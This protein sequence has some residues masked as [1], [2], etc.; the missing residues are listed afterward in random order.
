MPKT[1]VENGVRYNVITLKRVAVFPT[2][3]GELR[4]DAL[5]IESEATSGSSI[6]DPFFSMRSRYQPV[7]LSSRPVRIVGKA[8]PENAPP[9][10][11][12][13]VGSFRL[14]ASLDRSTMEVGES[15]QL[16][17][18][19]SGSGNIATLEGPN[20]DTPGIFEV[21]DPQVATDVSRTGSSVRGTK[22][23]TYI[24]VPR[25]NGTFE[26]P[27]IEFSFLNPRSGRYETLRSKT[28][29]VTVTGEAA[30]TNITAATS[31]GL[32]VDD[33]APITLTVSDWVRTDSDSI[34]QSF[35]VYL[36][37]ILPLGLVAGVFVY[38]R[39]NDKLTNDVT[40]ARN[41]R[42]HPIARKHLKRA[43]ELLEQGDAKGYY[44]ELDRA[45]LGFVGDRLDIGER[46]LTRSELN[47]TLAKA[48][49][50]A[51]A[52]AEVNA[53]LDECDQVRFAP[54]PPNASAMQTAMDRSSVLIQRIHERLLEVEKEAAA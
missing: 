49:I 24:L 13:A 14:S 40:Y 8:F 25:S 54:V 15:V 10:F 35:L 30:T 26:I 33:I 22:T 41:R 1:V 36:F 7:E 31:A 29:S 9:S 20:V 21:Y 50:Q 32:P 34:H 5:K 43:A 3:T 39:I 46:A 42:A 6:R 17:I 4:V 48:G 37:V 11:S 52:R 44:E 12:G 23:F 28:F 18:V 19:V 53:L 51:D 2:R 45:V 27:P 16:A 38:N 47:Q